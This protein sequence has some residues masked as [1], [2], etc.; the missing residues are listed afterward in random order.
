M[1][2]LPPSEFIKTLITTWAAANAWPISTGYVPSKED[3]SITLMDTGGSPANPKWLLDYPSVQ[4][5]VRGGQGG[6]LAAYAAANAL[7]DICLGVTSQNIN[8][9]R[10]VAINMESDILS[11]GNDENQRPMFSMNFTLITEP[12]TSANTNRLPL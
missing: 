12:A 9:D 4:I 2:V 10:L 8:G 7:K 1:S 5:F 11:L 6:Y 3:K